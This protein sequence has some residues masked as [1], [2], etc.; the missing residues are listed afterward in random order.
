M[1]R[2]DYTRKIK[3]YTWAS[4]WFHG[5]TSFWNRAYKRRRSIAL[6][7]QLRRL[8]AELADAERREDENMQV[9]GVVVIQSCVSI[10]TKLHTH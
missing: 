2:I 8:N 5:T 1:V 10:H 4:P 7:E 3:H 6:A 9:L